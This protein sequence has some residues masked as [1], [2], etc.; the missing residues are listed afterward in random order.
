MKINTKNS[1]ISKELS[2][3][4]LHQREDGIV[5]NPYEKEL[6]FY[7][8]VQA[9]DM[10]KVREIMTPLTSEGLGT[11]SKKPLRNLQYHLIV[12]IAL[13][14][15]FCIEGGLEQER[16]YS[17]SDL[18]I[19]KTDLCTC[20]QEITTLHESMIMEYT[21]RM[22]QLSRNKAKSKPIVLCLDYIHKHY[23][24]HISLQDIADS[25]GLNPT[26]LSNLFKK[27]MD[28]TVFQY[29]SETRLEA[30]M[31][32]LKYSNYSYSAISNYC[33]YSSQSHFTYCLRTHTG[34]TPRQYRNKYYSTN[35]RQ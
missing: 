2:D 4:L 18:F 10:E 30:S 34:L 1:K 14:T 7:S 24:G 17:L 5:H 22:S 13:I 12:C 32:L 21:K 26:Y 28:M 27:E 16:A 3:A 23:H 11:L 6:S 35:W 9:G 19:Q 25:I 8:A 29:I 15:R 20:E 33:G 31:N